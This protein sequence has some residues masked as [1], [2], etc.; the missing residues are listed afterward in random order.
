[1]DAIRPSAPQAQAPTGIPE[2]T[3]PIPIPIPNPT[4]IPIPVPAYAPIP[5]YLHLSFPM[6]SLY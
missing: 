5:F 1:M 6:V 4:S 2:S 3:A